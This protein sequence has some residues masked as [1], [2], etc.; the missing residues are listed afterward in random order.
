MP[1]SVAIFLGLDVYFGVYLINIF[2]YLCWA[3]Q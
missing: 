3:L 2:R 1:I